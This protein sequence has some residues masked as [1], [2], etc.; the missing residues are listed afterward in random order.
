MVHRREQF[1]LLPS[2]F[3][4]PKGRMLGHG[5]GQRMELRQPFSPICHRT[6]SSLK[7]P[8]SYPSWAHLGAGPD[9]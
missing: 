4:T 8:V 2:A 5:R 1:K 9:M 6:V 3:P 7:G